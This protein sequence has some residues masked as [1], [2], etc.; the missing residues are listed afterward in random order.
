[1]RAFGGLGLLFGL[2]GIMLWF[3]AISSGKEGMYLPIAFGNVAGNQVELNTIVGVTLAATSR[4]H[5]KEQKYKSWDDWIDDHF[6]LTDATG[7][8]FM[9][10]RR[11]N[12]KIISRTD[13]T[14]TVCTEEFYLS[15]T[16]T[17]GQPYVL[18]FIGDDESRTHYRHEFT[19]PAQ[20]EKVKNVML[21]AS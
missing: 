19:A 14:R 2:G 11:G 16:L 15:A 13:T 7:K 20:V 8:T 9:L 17:V 6:V 12:S 4:A 5:D 18:E 3:L 21:E 10:D 1:M